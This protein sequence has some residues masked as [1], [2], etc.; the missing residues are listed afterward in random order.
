MYFFAVV[1]HYHRWDG[2]KGVGPV[3]IRWLGKCSRLVMVVY[4]SKIWWHSISGEGG[5]WDRYTIHIRPV[6][7]FFWFVFLKTDMLCH[8]SGE[9]SKMYRRNEFPVIVFPEICIKDYRFLSN[10]RVSCPSVCPFIRLFV[11]GVC[12]LY[13]FSHPR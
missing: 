10:T 9:Q 12:M 2:A 8:F 5:G 13:R 7:S 3:A 11:W 1:F 4:G 6:I